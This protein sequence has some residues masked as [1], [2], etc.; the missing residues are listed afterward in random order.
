MKSTTALRIAAVTGFLAVALG[1]FGAHGLTRLL[2]ANQRTATW[3]TA[4]HYHLV[5]AVV[6]LVLALRPTVT[7]LS[8][9][10]FVAGIVIF[11]GSLYL[12]AVTNIRW[13]GAI[14][15]IGG[16]CLI[17]G[18]LALAICPRERSAEPSA[19]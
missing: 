14:T 17:A 15:P 19:K 2:E 9:T 6:L 8:F 18:W 12:L 1:A 4:A 10:L 11:S 7:R 5:H 13:L 3:Q 16:A